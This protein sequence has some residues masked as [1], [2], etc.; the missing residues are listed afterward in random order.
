MRELA[1]TDCGTIAKSHPVERVHRL[2]DQL[3]VARDLAE[4]AEDGPAPGLG[5]EHD[6]AAGRELGDQ[7]GD[8][9]GAGEAEA[10]AFDLV[11]IA[12]LASIEADRAGIGCELAGDQ[13]DQ[14]R[15]AGAVGA[16]QR[17]DLAGAQI[18]LDAVGDLERAEGFAQAGERQYRFSHDAPSPQQDL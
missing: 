14:A 2:V 10:G 13:L 8:L 5:R 9:E 12:D 16:D 6:I 15:L 7:R 17:M 18:E 11:E 4:E 1:D 3:A